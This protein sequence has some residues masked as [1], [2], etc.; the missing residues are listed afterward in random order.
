MEVAAVMIMVMV[1]TIMPTKVDMDI[2]TQMENHVPDMDTVMV[3]MVVMT[4]HTRNQSKEETLMLMQLS[5]MLS[6]I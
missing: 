3:M 4:T 5:F 2:L 1:N 6:E